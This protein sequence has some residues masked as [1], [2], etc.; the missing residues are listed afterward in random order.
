MSGSGCVLRESTS[1]LSASTEGSPRRDFAGRPATPT[2]SPT[3]T[4]SSP[5]TATSQITWIRPERSTT[6]RKTSFPIP[7]RAI[8]RPAILRVASA[9]APASSGSASARTAAISSRSGKR[10]GGG[11]SGIG[12]S[13]VLVP[14]CPTSS[15]TPASLQLRRSS[16][17][18]DGVP[19][20]RA[21][22]PGGGDRQVALRVP[23]ARSLLERC[24]STR[25]LASRRREPLELGE[26][27][28]RERRDV[29]STSGARGSAAAAAPLPGSMR[30]ISWRIFSGVG[31]E[32]EQDSRRD[33]LVLPHERRAGRARCRCSRG[34]ARRASRSASSSIFFAPGV[35]GIW[36]VVRT[37]SPLT[38]DPDDARPAPPRRV[39][40]EP[41]RARARRSPPPRAA[42]RAGCAPCRWRRDR[43]AGLVLRED[44]DL[45]R[46]LGEPLEHPRA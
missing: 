17:R 28:R 33:A 20:P 9:S 25:G 26:H 8:A 41:S 15:R 42:A 4:S 21:D 10:L 2:T 14:W 44:D 37:S 36:P 35:N 1:T 39:T 18:L 3:W 6:S 32:L 5:V 11:C 24:R 16:R 22:E 43:A 27:L 31:V 40:S 29:S 46:A 38:Q 45:A 12:G 7:R 19:A 13:Y 30:M 34:R 23:E